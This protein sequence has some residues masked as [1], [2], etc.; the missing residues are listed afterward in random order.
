MLFNALVLVL[1][2]FAAVSGEKTTADGYLLSSYYT[3]GSCSSTSSTY[4]ITGVAMNVCQK[5]TFEAP[6]YAVAQKYTN[7]NSYTGTYTLTKY[8]DASCSDDSVITKY[9]LSTSCSNGIQVSCSADDE[10][11]LKY[12]DGLLDV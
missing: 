6:D 8:M 5:A 11:W 2:F 7:C 1:T 9:T 10:P 4:K 3:G 12:S